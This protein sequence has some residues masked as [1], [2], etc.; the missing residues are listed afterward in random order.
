MHIGQDLVVVE[1]A[2]DCEIKTPVP[3]CG[4]SRGSVMHT[5]QFGGVLVH[6]QLFYIISSTR[7]RQPFLRRPS[8]KADG[9][10]GRETVKVSHRTAPYF[11]CTTRIDLSRLAS[12]E[13]LNGRIQDSGLE[14]SPISFAGKEFEGTFRGKLLWQGGSVRLRIFRRKVCN[15]DKS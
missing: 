13:L 2:A 5:K 1:T 6:D 12:V 14:V 10:T 7:R 9:R 4:R 11:W 15:Y 8:Q 3:F